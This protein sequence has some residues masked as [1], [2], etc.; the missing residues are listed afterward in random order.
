M[1]ACGSEDRPGGRQVSGRVAV[2]GAAP[3]EDPG[4]VAVLDEQVAWD[5]V[6]V[7][8]ARRGGVVQFVRLGGKL[9]YTPDVEEPAGAGTEPV[10][11]SDEN[12]DMGSDR[13]AQVA[14]GALGN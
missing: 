14:D 13:D 1:T 3:V 12:V 9:A 10:E 6:V 8:E 2:A 5:Q 4:D 7:N 11:P